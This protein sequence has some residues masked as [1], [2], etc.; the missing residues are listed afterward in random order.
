VNLAQEEKGDWYKA[1]AWRPLVHVCRKWRTIVFGSPRRLDRR[2]LCMART[3]VKEMLAVWPPLPIIISPGV[4]P[5]Q[6]DNIIAAL[7]HTDRVCQ[8]DLHIANSQLEDVL[9]AMRIP[10]PALTKLKIWAAHWPE[11]ETRPIV[12]ESFLGGF[13]P[14]LQH[15]RLEGILFPGLHKLILTAIDLVKLHIDRIPHSGYISPEAMVHCL[16]TLTRLEKLSLGF[17]SPLSF[18][19]RGSRC[20][21][22]RTRSVLPALT[23]FW[24]EGVSEYLEDFVA[25]IDAPLLDDLYI[26]FF[27]QLIFDTPQLTQFVARTS[28]FQPVVEVCIEFGDKFVE[29]TSLQSL[30][31]RFTLGISCNQSDWQLSSLAQVCSSSFP[32]AL[33]PTAERLYIRNWDEYWQDDIEDSQWLEVLHPFTVVRD[34]YL[35]RESVSCIAPALQDLS[36][37]LLPSLQNI[38]TGDLHLVW[39]CRSVERAANTAAI[40]L[41]PSLPAYEEL[42]NSEELQRATSNQSSIGKFIA[43]R[44]HAGHPIAVSY[45]NRIF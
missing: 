2:L 25:R 1:Q 23:D 29:V 33:I 44:Q 10:F 39:S 42:T 16:T 20:P 4:E 24:F 34:L 36:G 41:S 11:G 15:L 22:L 35:F 14:R 28:N 6:I 5:V 17:E 32:Q 37:E 7:E 31:G 45:C 27:H 3:P 30:S 19:V 38:F 21:P 8:I 40:P 43:A 9:A 18:P 26:Y 13:A 12:L